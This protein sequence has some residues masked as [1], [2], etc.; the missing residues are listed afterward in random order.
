M[1]DRVE[2]RRR[3]IRLSPYLLAVALAPAFLQTSTPLSCGG[4][5]TLSE[6]EVFA[7]GENQIIGFDPNQRS[8]H[9]TLPPG[10]DEVQIRAVTGDPGARV[11][12]DLF[13]DGEQFGYQDHGSSQGYGVG[14][15]DVLVPIPPG[16]SVVRTWVSPSGGP[17]GFYDVDVESASDAS[18][19]VAGAPVTVSGLSPFTEC[20]ADIDQDGMF[21]LHS[22]VEPWISVNPLDPS[23]LVAAWQQD[24]YRSGGGARAHMVAVSFDGGASWSPVNVP[25]LSPC[26]GGAWDRVT[27]PWLTFAANGDLYAASA[28]WTYVDTGGAIVVNQSTDGG[29]TWSAPVIVDQTTAP[30]F[31][32][33]ETMIADPVDPCTVYLIWTRF[34]SAPP[35]PGDVWFSKTTDC[36]ATW[37]TPVVVQRWDP[38]GIAAQIVPLPS[39]DLL[40]FYRESQFGGLR[41]IFVE[42]SADGGLTWPDDPIVVANAVQSRV[43]SPD[44][45]LVR[46]SSFDV[47]VNHDTGDVYV[48]WERAFDA[49]LQVALSTSSDGGLTWSAPIRIDDTP[50]NPAFTLAQAFIPTV[51][52]SAEGTIGVTYY[53]F[54]N[55][56]AGATPTWSDHWFVSCDPGVA[57]CG[58]PG[59]WGTAI[60]LTPD[61]FDYSLAPSVSGSNAGLFLGDYVGLATAGNDFFAFFSVTTDD[62]PANAIFVPIRA[63]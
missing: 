20:D 48:V 4:D 7:Q 1:T 27:D 56:M 54:Q 30:Q 36:G 28:T 19:Y 16:S 9:A 60:R 44:G 59:S 21:A 10:T 26:T 13:V 24:R 57:D 3:T 39:G 50:P 46:S 62:D 31:N 43:F 40:A 41:P 33:R 5:S 37:T 29:L 45:A 63:R 61:S 34:L 12:V 8:Y 23:H 6:L 49:A 35:S 2:A 58:D 47:G 18:A 55:D 51:E 53:G 22:E 14:G 17:T 11:W 38:A 42:R 52:V 32:D 15:T 25:G